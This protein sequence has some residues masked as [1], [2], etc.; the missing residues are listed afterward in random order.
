MARKVP[1]KLLVAGKG[2]PQ[3]YLALAERLGMKGRLSF[4][5]VWPRIEEL[6][7]ISDV[8]V[9]PTIYDPFANACLEAM[10][11]GLP[12]ITTASNGASELIVD[13]CHGFILSDPT[14]HHGLGARILDLADPDR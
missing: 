10:A 1:L 14:D 5:G 6:Y 3:A 13:G 12:V 9:L 7:A 8:F 11:S 4:V 2:N